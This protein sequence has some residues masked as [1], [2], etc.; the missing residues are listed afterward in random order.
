M[1]K[2]LIVDD[3]DDIRELLRMTLLDAPVQIVG[4]A[5]NGREALELVAETSPH[6]VLMDIMMPV[7]G[8][9]EATRR[10]RKEHPEVIVVGFTAAYQEHVDEMINAGAV[11]VFE[12]TSFAPLIQQL[13]ELV[14]P[15]GFQAGSTQV[16]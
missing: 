11:A 7:M 8:G 16:R 1:I 4:E 14:S 10:I 6:L 5:A 15:A 13:S 12:K 9:I 3:Q 2:L